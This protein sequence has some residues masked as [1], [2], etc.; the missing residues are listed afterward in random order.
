MIDRKRM[1]VPSKPGGI[2]QST[3]SLISS[4]MNDCKLSHV[5]RKRLEK[6]LKRTTTYCFMYVYHTAYLVCCRR[7]KAETDKR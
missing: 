4:I 6:G 3:M 1:P 2:S 5:E 7:G